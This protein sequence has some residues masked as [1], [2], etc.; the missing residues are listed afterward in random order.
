MPRKQKPKV[1]RTAT[2]FHDAY[3]AAPSRKAALAAWGSKHDLFASGAAEIVDDPELIKEPLAQPGV[4]FHRSR[5]TAEEQLAALRPAPNAKRRIPKEEPSPNVHPAK[6][7]LIKKKAAPEKPKLDR[8]AL[9]EAERIL[10]ALEKRHSEERAGMA[11]READLQ[12]Q[13]KAHD[14]R[15]SHEIDEQRLKTDKFRAIYERAKRN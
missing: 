13:R 15:Q 8:T 6:A 1:F 11:Q 10:A 12:R 4:V 14:K 3:V 5:G 7:A 9:D 2:G